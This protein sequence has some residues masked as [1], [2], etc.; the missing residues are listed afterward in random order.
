ML[1]NLDDRCFV[2]WNYYCVS[3][4][5]NEQQQ[6]LV[7]RFQHYLLNSS[8]IKAKT[9]AVKLGPGAAVLFKDDQLLHGRNA[10]EATEIGER[11]LYKCGLQVGSQL[12]QSQWKGCLT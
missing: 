9:I 4:D 1:S 8:G 12:G 6:Q 10:F 3:T 7:S 11:H 2:N 5:I